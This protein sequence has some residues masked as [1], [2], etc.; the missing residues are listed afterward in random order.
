MW[1]GVSSPV[2]FAFENA[3]SSLNLNLT[4]STSAREEWSIL[5]C[6]T[7][8]HRPHLPERSGASS[9]AERPGNPRHQRSSRIAKSGGSGL[10]C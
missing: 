5:R 8:A 6:G 1:N 3:H 9:D 4:P 10:D 7:K 2:P